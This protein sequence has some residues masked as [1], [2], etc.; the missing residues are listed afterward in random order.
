MDGSDSDPYVISH[1]VWRGI[2]RDMERIVY[3]TAFGDNPRSPLAVRKPAEWEA[4]VKVIS[5]VV[6]HGRLPE[7]YYREWINL[8]KAISLATD[9]SICTTD[10]PRLRTMMTRC[11][12]VCVILHSYPA[13]NG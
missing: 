5:P 3:S 13:N 7:P 10:I 2:E 6:P 1:N 9:Y 8:V 11:V 4:W 12:P